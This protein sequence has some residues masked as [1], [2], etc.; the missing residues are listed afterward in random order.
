MPEEKFN[1]IN[2]FDDNIGNLDLCKNYIY[3]LKLVEDRYYIGRTTNILKRI[4]DHFTNNGAIYTKTFKPLKVIEIEEELTN[5]DERKMTF[6]YVEKYGWEKVRG[7]FWCSLVIK[8]H[9]NLKN[10]ENFKKQRED[11]K[12]KMMEIDKELKEMYIFEN[13]NIIDI[14]EKLNITPGK[15]AFRLAKLKI[16]ENKKDAKGYDEYKNSDLYKKNC[17]RYEKQIQ[18]IEYYFD[19]EIDK[20]ILSEYE[21]QNNDIFSISINNKIK[22]FQVVSILMRHKIIHKRHESR[23]YDEYKETDEYKR[24]LTNIK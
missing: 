23:G 15:L 5:D 9:L 20:K 13:K 21:I 14:G 3:V 10:Y 24:K 6:K 19:E 22:I 17:D 16:I 12:L 1:V 4:T 2:C 11:E 18:K 7:S 8:K